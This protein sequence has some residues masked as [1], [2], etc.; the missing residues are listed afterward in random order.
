MA[1]RPVV[2]EVAP[3]ASVASFQGPP[4]KRKR[5][6]NQKRLTRQIQEATGLP[7]QSCVNLMR[8]AQEKGQ[9][10]EE[11]AIER[12]NVNSEDDSHG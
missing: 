3:V 7:Y 1:I 10:W 8:E 11:L 6:K 4:T 2:L 12:M 5:S 9:P